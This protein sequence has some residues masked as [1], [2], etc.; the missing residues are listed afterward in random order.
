MYTGGHNMAGEREID[1]ISLCFD[2]P[3][4]TECGT[5]LMPGFVIS[6]GKKPKA[7]NEA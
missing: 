7:K 1:K 6:C 3:L 5:A 2:C 4:N